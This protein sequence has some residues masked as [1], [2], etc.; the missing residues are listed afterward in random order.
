MFLFRRHCAVIAG[1]LAAFLTARAGPSLY[2]ETLPVTPVSIP[3]HTVRTGGSEDLTQKVKVQS[4]E[5]EAGKTLSIPASKPG[6]HLVKTPEIA[7]VAE[8]LPNALV[9]K[10]LR[11]GETSILVWEAEG[12][13]SYRIVVVR[14]RQERMLIEK[15]VMQGSKLY[16]MKR[17]RSFKVYYDTTWSFLNE[18]RVLPRA[19]E[20]QKIYNHRV[21]SS[22]R[23]PY[24]EFD[25]SLFYEYRK[26]HE[27]EKSVAI[28]R[29][30]WGGLYDTDL[31]LL[32]HYDITAGEQFV[33][34]S[35]FGFPGERINGISLLPSSSR[36]MSP[37]AGQLDTSFFL[38]AKRDGSMI[39]NPAGI[40]DRKV[41][42]NVVGQRA[43]YH[44]WKNGTVSLG[45][46]H[47]WNNQRNE[48][49]SKNNYNALFDFRFP[50]VQLK[51]EGAF[52]N[53]IRPAAQLRPIFQ[54][55]WS[56]VEGRWFSVDNHYATIPGTVMDRGARGYQTRIDAFPLM[57]FV[58]SDAIM[59][60]G[61]LGLVRNHLSVNPDRP[62]DYVKLAQGGVRWR[63][64][65]GFSNDFRM[66]FVDQF[67]A[68]FP[69]TQKRFNEVFTKD[70][71]FRSKWLKRS[72]AFISA[73]YDAYRKARNTPGFNSTRWEVGSGGS[74]YFA[75]GW[76]ASARYYRNELKELDVWTSPSKVTY[77]QQFVV[78]GGWTHAFR[79]IP[80]SVNL[81]VRYSKD[82]Q[83]YGKI[84]QPFLNEERL[85][86]RT[87][88]N[89]YVRD[90]GS[91]FAQV[92]AAM[93]R[94][95]IGAPDQAEF[96]FVTGLQMMW[97]TKLYVPQSGRI[98]GAVFEDRNANGMRDD[99]EPGIMGYEVRIE[100]G[101]KAETD[102]DGFYS[103]KVREGQVKVL[104]SGKLP[105]GFYFTT[106][107]WE[108]IEVLP[109]TFSRVDFG[110]AP[111]IQVRGHV[112][113]DVNGNK[114]F[115]K[116][117]VPVAGIQIALASGQMGVSASEGFYSILRVTPGPNKIR[118]VLG[119][120]PQGYKTLVPVEKVFE[121]VAGDVI[122]YPV[123][124]AAQR[125]AS[126]YVFGDDNENGKFDPVEKGIAGV[127][128]LAGD[129]TYTTNRSGKFVIPD[130]AAAK[131]TL[132]LDQSSLPEGDMAVVTSKELETGTGV[133]IDNA[134]HFPVH[135]SAKKD[136]E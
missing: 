11:V 113:V 104:A 46:F 41:K 63:L 84:H 17:A 5:V 87:G 32:K 80:M 64:P 106:P 129:K 66:W 55:R 38:G 122:N 116:G 77:P 28:P 95:N 39:D 42:G 15:T 112:F 128:I 90:V 102:K 115:E 10:G 50:Y 103:L 89:F 43:D 4:Y 131:A 60:D 109:K 56:R 29:D 26:E 19:T 126:G 13:K 44:V 110:V 48:Y 124:L 74:L 121:G 99:G 52:D 132:E 85:E 16:Q 108:H 98:E 27:M 100:D 92:R 130:L 76:Y 53:R 125:T 35:D 12:V 2:A 47:Q 59:I 9:I 101:A 33:S 88:A 51:G 61:D 97:D 31:P 123:I 105:E 118:V 45:S 24:G 18:G 65:Y 58:N 21:R 68:S 94:S 71:Y 72:S 30:F 136:S 37:K 111:Q 107:N 79:K 57:P 7:V 93:I 133:F 69:Y 96:S 23:T 22:G 20:A 8:T 119:S 135:I 83:T 3:G 70:V 54:N 134:V 114:I 75:G 120:I 86:G 67:A 14:P 91:L 117:D 73:A 1:L 81:D 82:A 49:Q 36:W 6:F 25:G 62:R 127:K 34:L 78:E 40:Q